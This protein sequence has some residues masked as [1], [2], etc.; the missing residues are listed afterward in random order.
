VTY[1]LPLWSTQSK[2][3]VYRTVKG[4]QRGLLLVHR[5]IDDKER[6]TITAMR[7]GRAVWLHV[8]CKRGADTLARRLQKLPWDF[9][10]KNTVKPASDKDFPKS[11]VQGMETARQIIAAFNCPDHGPLMSVRSSPIG[12]RGGYHGPVVSNQV[13]SRYSAYAQEQ[14]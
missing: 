5:S 1:K 12:S 6:Y 8:C 13:Y 11:V 2:A 10:V 7:S 3:T 9:P 14:K 4:T